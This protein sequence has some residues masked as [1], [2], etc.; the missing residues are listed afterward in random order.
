VATQAIVVYTDSPGGGAAVSQVTYSELTKMHA[1]HKKPIVS[2]VESVGASGAYYVASATD[3][4]YANAASVVG[5][6]GVIAEWVNYGDLMKWAKL[7]PVV[8]QAGKLRSA[9]DPSRD[10]TPEERAE[11]ERYRKLHL[12]SSM[13]QSAGRK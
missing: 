11:H 9:G 12:A 7:K 5:S 10:M 1:K 6:V 13:E 8:L 4:I 2:S 3:K